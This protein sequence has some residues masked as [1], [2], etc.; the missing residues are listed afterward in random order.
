M[1]NAL[2]EVHEGPQCAFNAIAW[3]LSISPL[4][5][6]LEEQEISNELQD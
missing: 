5:A 6:E 2:L 4:V 1:G 3:G